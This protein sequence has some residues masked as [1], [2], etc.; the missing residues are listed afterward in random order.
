MAARTGATTILRR[1]GEWIVSA[2]VRVAIIGSGPAGLS[3]AAHA[4]KLG[5]SHVLIEKAGHLSDTIWNYSHGKHVMATPSNL[6]L[7]ANGGGGAG[8][9]AGTAYYFTGFTIDAEGKVKLPY[10]GESYVLG[11]TVAEAQVEIENTLKKFFKIFHLQV[12]VAEFKFSVLGSVGRP[13]QYFFQQNKVNI[14]EAIAQA[15]DLQ[16]M[17]KRRQVQLYRQ[18]PEG[19]KV[20]NLD[21]TDRALINS[22]YWYIQPND[23]LYIVPVKGRSVGDL[24]TAQSAFGVVGPLLGSLLTVFNTYFLLKNL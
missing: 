10:A 5:L 13:G 17:A 23:V 9:G 24:S 14:L 3:A 22:P 1:P 6:V 21:L 19:I 15:G 7:R 12:K 18:C 2:G 16:S 8:G 11:K 20:V 4:A